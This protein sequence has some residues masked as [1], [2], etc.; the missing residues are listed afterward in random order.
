MVVVVCEWDEEALE[1]SSAAQQ[2]QLEV[3]RAG[4]GEHWTAGVEGDWFPSSGPKV[5]ETVA[6]TGMRRYAVPG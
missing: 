3:S 2:L 6:G 4:D 1:G 5:T